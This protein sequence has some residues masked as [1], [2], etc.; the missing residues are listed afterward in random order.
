M[1]KM[2]CSLGQN[3][4]KLECAAAL[5]QLCRPPLFGAHTLSEREVSLYAL[6]G[7]KCISAPIDVLP[8]F[9]AVK[10]WGTCKK[11]LG[12]LTNYKIHARCLKIIAN[13]SFNIATWELYLH[14]D[15]TKCQKIVSFWKIEA[16]GQTVLPAR[17]VLKGQKMPK[18]KSSNAIFF[19]DFQP[20]WYPHAADISLGNTH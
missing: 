17:S 18:L 15:W 14:F 1:S 11:A 10:L 9:S 6:W 20:M 19:G 4:Q 13:V 12:N 2:E 16:C 7:N 3:G 8:L 5:L